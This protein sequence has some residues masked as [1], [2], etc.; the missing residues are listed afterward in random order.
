M[1]NFKHHIYFLGNEEAL[2][3]RLHLLQAVLLYHQNR[4]NEALRMFQVT[5]NELNSLKIEENSIVHLLELGN[6]M[7]QNFSILYECLNINQ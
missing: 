4:R 7:Q 1:I 6:I 5:E 2:V 3:M